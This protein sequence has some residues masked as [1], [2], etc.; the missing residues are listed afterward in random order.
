LNGKYQNRDLTKKR[1]ITI[2]KR[3]FKLGLDIKVTSPLALEP[4]E[5]LEL[6]ELNRFILTGNYPK[7]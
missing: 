4:K 5:M 6:G 3:R 1:K 7:K 2:K